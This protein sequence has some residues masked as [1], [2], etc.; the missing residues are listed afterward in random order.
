MLNKNSCAIYNTPIFTTVP[1]APTVPNFK[2]RR[3]EM[4]R[5]N[6]AVRILILNGDAILVNT[7]PQGMRLHQHLLWRDL[8]QALIVAIAR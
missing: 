6:E 3:E 4:R 7:L 1:D 8:L 5:I 2:K